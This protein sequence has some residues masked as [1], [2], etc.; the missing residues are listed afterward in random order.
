MK[1]FYTLVLFWG[2]AGLVLAGDH[3]PE[4]TWGDITNNYRAGIRIQAKFKEKNHYTALYFGTTNTQ[5]AVEAY[6]PGEYERFKAVVRDSN[7]VEI[8]KTRLG[9]KY[10][11]AP[12]KYAKFSDRPFR[13]PKR[14]KL[15]RATATLDSQVCYFNIKDHFD[16]TQPGFYTLMVE[17]RIYR[18]VGNGVLQLETLPPCSVKFEFY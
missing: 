13:G 5:D 18:R 8:S 7:G 3:V 2:L 4:I 9:E 17:L 1:T 11:K 6:A 12:M 15:L 14:W 16:I 10:D